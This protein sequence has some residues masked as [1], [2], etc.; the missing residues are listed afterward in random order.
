MNVRTLLTVLALGSGAAG[1]V[2]TAYADPVAP[3][4]DT[5]CATE[6]DGALTGAAGS[7]TLLQCHDGGW[8][9][10]TDVYPASD[11]WLTTSAPLTLHGQGMRNP[12][13]HAGQWTATPQDAETQCSA[14][15]VDVLGPGE[16][17]APQVL[18][19]DPG[20]PLSYAVSA[21]LFSVTLS[22]FCLWQRAS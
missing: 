22:G 9:P 5:G 19:G 6:L 7:D 17:G 16:L 14:R 1:G 13:V 2:P 11:R 12:E 3:Q 18:T 10:Y 4:P 15:Q 20:Q 21:K 8:Q